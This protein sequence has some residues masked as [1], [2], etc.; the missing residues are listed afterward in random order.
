MIKPINTWFNFKTNQYD[1][2]TTAPQTDAEAVLYISQ[3]PAVQGLY[4]V[5]RKTG[6]SIQEAMLWVLSAMVGEEYIPPEER[7]GQ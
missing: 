1:E 4:R 6:Y 3:E 7:E 2:L 5:L